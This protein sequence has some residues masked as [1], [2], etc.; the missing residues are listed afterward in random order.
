MTVT[1]YLQAQVQIIKLIMYELAAAVFRVLFSCMCSLSQSH[2]KIECQET[3]TFP[4]S[5]NVCF[6]K[7]Q[8]C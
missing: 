5:Q 3:C 2:G 6:E 7:V 1:V 4:I 8:L